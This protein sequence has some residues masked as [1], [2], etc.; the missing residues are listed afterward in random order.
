MITEEQLLELSRKYAEKAG[1]RLNPDKE[2][3]DTVIKGL[4]ENEKR[5]GLRYC[6][7]RL[8]TGDRQKD[9]AIICPC[10][11]HKDEIKQQGYC[12]CMLYFAKE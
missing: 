9:A 1:F 6:P 11:Y 4:I 7:C 10:R 12:H 2:I 8:L 5:H 3:L